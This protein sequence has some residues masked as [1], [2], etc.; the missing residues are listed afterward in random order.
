LS[1]SELVYESPVSLLC[2][3]LWLALLLGVMMMV[4]A[5]LPGDIR[6]A[7]T[8]G[9]KRQATHIPAQPLESAL[10]SLAQQRDFQVVYRSELV[11]KFSCPALE[12]NFT[13][14]AA[15]TRLLAGTGLTFHYLDENTVTVVPGA[16]AAPLAVGHSAGNGSRAG[17]ESPPNSPTGPV[18]TPL[19]AAPMQLPPAEPLQSAEQAQVLITANK[20]VEKLQDVPASIA[21]L[22]ADYLAD[23]E[24]VS[25][26][27]YLTAVPGVSYYQNA[28]QTNAIF[29]RGVSAGVNILSSSTTGIYIDDAPVTQSVGGTVDLNTF[30]LARVEVLR[31]PQGT[32]YG[33]A[34]MGGTVR[35]ITNKP[36]LSSIATSVE[37]ELSQTSH[38]TLSYNTN[39]MFNLPLSDTLGLRVVGGF[40]ES[41]GFIDE[42]DLGRN[43]ANFDQTSTLRAQMRWQ[44]NGRTD[45]LLSVFYQ[46]E[47][48]G[49]H[50]EAYPGPGFGPYQGGVNFPEG[51]KQPFTLYALTLNDDLGFA[52]LT[53]SSSYY[54]KRS[55]AERENPDGEVML[56]VSAG[57]GEQ[58]IYEA[59]TFSQEIRLASASAGPYRWLVGTFYSDGKGPSLQGYGLSTLPAVSAE[60]LYNAD[61]PQRQHQSALFGEVGRTL[62]D[63][64]TFTAGLRRS[65]YSDHTIDRESGVFAGGI[66]NT[67]SGANDHFLNQRYT[68]S[69]TPVRD[70]LFYVQAASGSRPGGPTEAAG[71]TESCRTDLVSLGFDPPPV[72]TR[73][74]S[75]WTYEVGSKS[76]FGERVTLNTALYYTQWRDIQSAVTL[77][78]GEQFPSN[79]GAADI[80]GAEI[81]LDAKPT[82][83]WT[84]TAS[85][86]FTDSFVT[87]ANASVGAFVGSPLPLVPQFNGAVGAQYS[88]ALSANAHAYVR[89]DAKYV[90]HE[91]ADFQASPMG[92]RMPA[93]TLMDARLGVRTGRYDVALYGTNLFDNRIVLYEA[94]DPLR[95]T[96]ARPR[97]VGVE[98]RMSH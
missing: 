75:L 49:A 40:R 96:L 44:P 58:L 12:G 56:G 92:F 2:A 89:T 51:G 50:P 18:S 36:D 52:T 74:D 46:D 9:G 63:G 15:L 60:N 25:F 97:T 26:Q 39:A 57:I 69:Y 70:Q 95:Q 16:E 66:V 71:L 31:G 73:P 93:Y 4:L 65:Q 82:A 67:D 87:A 37:T 76:S 34:S 83:G 7:E 30:D 88:F 10:R 29:I 91:Y 19:A 24:S 68:L 35:L 86:A 72:Q 3:P 59:A 14:D 28:A 77:Q 1:E 20:R 6:A 8:A 80:R 38:G 53:S 13:R 84:L 79:A 61:I 21:V 22:S 98:F 54:D 5:C 33:A 23:T 43:D 62:L 47:V 90:G 32:L 81:A 45:V 94:V 55:V 27:D 42:V 41:G 11:A 78:C 64:L 85:A 17:V 48:Y